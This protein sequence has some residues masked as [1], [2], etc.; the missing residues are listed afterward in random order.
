MSYRNRPREDYPASSMY[1]EE[2]PVNRWAAAAQAA[3]SA[4]NGGTSTGYRSWETVEEEPEDYDNSDWLERKTKKVQN[5]SL[6]STRRALERL[7]ETDSLAQQNMEKLAQQSEQLSKMDGRLESA[8]SHVKVSDAKA[9]HL[10]SL[11]RFFMLPSFG[12]KKAKKKEAAAKREAEERAAREDERRLEEKERATRVERMQQVQGAQYTS[13]GRMYTTPDGIERDDTEE[14]IDRNLDQISSGLSKLKM[15][16]QIMNSE[17]DAQNVQ[18]NRLA[19]RSESTNE[20]LKVTTHK[21][22]RI[23]GK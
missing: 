3:E 18:V 6:L 8:H 19:D 2:E 20:R 4:Y 7:N 9:D 13:V 10:K 15:M 23:I 22:Q 12:S 14:E 21:V 17:L 1:P 11:N 5:D 16:G